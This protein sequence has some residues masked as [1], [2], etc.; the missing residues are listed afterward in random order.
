[1]MPKYHIGT[2]DAAAVIALANPEPDKT[3]SAELR[4]TF[5]QSRSWTTALLTAKK[6]VS[7]DTVIFSFKLQH[8]EQTLGLP[9]GQHIMIRL[10]DPVSREAIIRSYTPIS[11]ISQRGTFDVLIKLY[12]SDPNDP[13]SGREGGKMSTALST[14]PLG[15]GVD[16]KGPIGKFEYTGRGTVKLQGQ[17]RHVR[18]FAMICAGSGITPIFQVFRAVMQDAEDPT[19]CTVINGNRLVE[20]ILCRDDLDALL[21][22]NEHRGE[23]VYTLTRPPQEGWEGLRGRIDKELIRRR[24]TRDDGE[25]TIILVCGPEALEKA[26][27]QALREQGWKDEQIVFF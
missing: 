26:V 22:G 11:S 13:A 20:D 3:A 18:R 17:E 12:L 25:G 8:E 6:R 2:L 27:H 19:C 4:P 9:V 7:S 23:V 1:M 10:R 21:R 24:C 16:F 14:I 5:L 15:H